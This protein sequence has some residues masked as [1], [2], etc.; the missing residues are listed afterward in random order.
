MEETTPD[1]TW[2]DAA[3]L[4]I[5][6]QAWP[7]ESQ[8]WTRLPDRAEGSVPDRVWDLS[9]ASAGIRVRFVGAITVAAVRWRLTAGGPLSHMP[10]S[11]SSGFDLYAREL[12]APATAWRHVRAAWPARDHDQPQEQVI[13]EGMDGTEREY[14]LYLPLYRGATDIQIGTDGTISAA[15]ADTSP[16]VAFYGTSIV[17]GGCANRPG[18]AYPAQIARKLGVNHINLGFS[19]NGKCQPPVVDLLTELTPDVWVV[20]PLA[21]LSV[22]ELEPAVHDALVA[23]GKA[24]PDIPI[25]AV[26]SPDYANSWIS[27]SRAER[28]KSSNESLVRAVTRAQQAGVQVTLPGGD[29]SQ[30]LFGTDGE[31]TVDGTHPTD[32]GFLRM[33]ETIGAE[34]EKLLGR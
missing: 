23:I 16:V 27:A 18:M 17:H 15:A 31:G 13:L 29:F 32:L 20:D 4:R 25:L 7:D 12:G 33:A 6:G 9:R 30:R 2:T 8:P 21:N 11:G 19:G 22:D 14:C 34:V 28:V 26:P 10:D 5:E 24:H 3:T 1:L